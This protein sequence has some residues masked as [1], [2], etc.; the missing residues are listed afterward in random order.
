MSDADHVQVRLQQEYHLRVLR[1]YMDCTSVDKPLA[2]FTLTLGDG[3]D[4]ALLTA[5]LPEL[6]FDPRTQDDRQSAVLPDTYAIPVHVIEALKAWLDADAA[7]GQPL[8]LRLSVPL[9]LL[10]AVPWEELLQ[11][12][13][14][15]PILRLPYQALAPRIP[16]AGIDTVVCLSSPGDEP[17]LRER[18]D[19]FVSDVPRELAQV[20]RFHLFGERAMHPYLRGLQRRYQDDVR[21]EV[22][23]PRGVGT[24]AAGAQSANPWLAWIEAELGQ[25]SVDFVHFICHGAQ[26]LDEGML[27]L[28]AAPGKAR[29]G[30]P[31][32]VDQASLVAFLDY[33]GAWSV[34]F[35]SVPSERSAAGLRMLQTAVAQ[36]RP[37]PAVVHDMSVQGSREAL[38]ATYRFLLAEPDRPPAAAAVSLY[39]HPVLLAAHADDPVSSRQLACYTLDERL[40]GKVSD[41]AIPWLASSQRKLESTAGAL[42]EAVEAGAVGRAHARKLVLDAVTR[43]VRKATPGP[44]RRRS[45]S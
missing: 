36:H 7:P 21:I 11:P 14:G 20:T 23:D 5:S 28:A 31:T 13:L 10:A 2:V 32:C 15:V 6:G 41:P 17:D 26:A 3:N 19:A 44:S 25:G 22:Y 39:C 34:A 18:I 35:T 38:Q 12:Q 37:G 27:L 33:L 16:R 9:G 42:A 29:S 24:A 43:E 1:L 45:P 4:V 8:W 40:H 30:Q